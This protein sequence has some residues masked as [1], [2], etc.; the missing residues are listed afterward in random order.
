MKTKR[1]AAL[2]MVGLLI[3]MMLCLG[4]NVYAA[5]QNTTKTNITKLV[6]KA[7]GKIYLTWSK[8]NVDGYQVRWAPNSKLTGAKT[9][10]DVLGAVNAGANSRSGHIKR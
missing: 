9:A 4:T 2:L 5:A 6:E 3:L 7:E 8:K 1:F 10:S